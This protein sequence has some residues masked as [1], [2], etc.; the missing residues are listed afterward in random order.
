MQP[1]IIIISL[2]HFHFIISHNK[3]FLNF[4]K[5]CCLQLMFINKKLLLQFFLTKEVLHSYIGLLSGGITASTIPSI[6]AP[7]KAPII[8]VENPSTIFP[9]I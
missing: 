7:I 6:K 8:P 9:V 2:T 1:P 5:I 4:H 3:A